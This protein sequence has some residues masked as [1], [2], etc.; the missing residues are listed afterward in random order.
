[1]NPVVSTSCCLYLTVAY[2]ISYIET[3]VINWQQKNVLRKEYHESFLKSLQ[4]TMHLLLFRL[5]LTLVDNWNTDVVWRCLTC[6]SVSMMWT[7]DR[8]PG[9]PM[10]WIGE[11]SHSQIG[12]WSRYIFSSSFFQVSSQGNW[13]ADWFRFDILD[14]RVCLSLNQNPLDLK[15]PTRVNTLPGRTGRSGRGLEVA[16]QTCI[17]S[18]PGGP[19]TCSVLQRWYTERL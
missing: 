2:L 16:T 9:G 19:S 14:S 18:P 1:M 10:C 17:S 7:R 13:S 3:L 12:A 5:K 11:P 4:Q 6:L 8:Y 15:R